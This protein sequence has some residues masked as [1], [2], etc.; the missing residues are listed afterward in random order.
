MAF[1]INRFR[2]EMY[3][4]PASSSKYEVVITRLPSALR[5]YNTKRLRFRVEDAEFP[6]KV[7]STAEFKDYGPTRKIA[8]GAMYNDVNLQ[9]MVVDDMTEKRLFDDWHNYIIDDNRG[10]DLEYYN[11]YVGTIEI[12]QFNK[13]GKRVYTVVLDE[14]YPVTV[15]SLPLSWGNTNQYHKLAVDIAYR[16]Y[17]IIT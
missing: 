7:I 15:Q 11:N 10:S 4:E 3:A 13:D 9:F 16:S 2:G 17:R 6:G 14:A 5:G 1:D 8:Y 12:S